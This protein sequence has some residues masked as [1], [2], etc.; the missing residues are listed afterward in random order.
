MVDK[1][2]NFRSRRVIP[3][4][5]W[6]P[7]LVITLMVLCKLGEVMINRWI[8]RDKRRQIEDLKLRI[9][10]SMNSNVRGF[11]YDVVPTKRKRYADWSRDG[12]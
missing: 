5:V 3:H 1:A 2:S 6:M 11:I 4:Y 8:E 7:I 12:F 10:E 9:L